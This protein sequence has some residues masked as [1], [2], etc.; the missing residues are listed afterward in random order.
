MTMKN[1]QTA[2]RCTTSKGLK[3]PVVQHLGLLAR[4]GFLSIRERPC[5]G[6]WGEVSLERRVALLWAPTLGSGERGC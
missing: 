6:D 3:E 1:P 5:G 4:R 2:P